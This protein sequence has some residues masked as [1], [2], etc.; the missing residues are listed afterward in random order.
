[1][2]DFSH[3]ALYTPHGT[4]IPV[5]SRCVCGHVLEWHYRLILS[6][7][8][9]GLVPAYRHAQSDRCPSHTCDCPRPQWD[10]Q[11]PAKLANVLAAQGTPAEPAA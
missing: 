9:G 2:S 10:G 3:N 7:A 8:H 6:R 1:M 4:A 5:V 11:E